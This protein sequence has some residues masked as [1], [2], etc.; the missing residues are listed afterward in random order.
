MNRTLPW[1]LGGAFAFALSLNAQTNPDGSADTGDAHDG[2]KLVSSEPPAQ[3]AKR[4]QW[5]SEARFGM[6]IHWGLYAQDGCFY[7]GQDGKTEHMMRHLQI[8]LKDYAK[9]ADD[10]NP[11]KFSADEWVG[12]A[13]NA[14]MKYMIITSKHH[15]G[16][17]MFNSPSSD[18]NIVK[19]TPWKRDPVKELAE[20]CRK[21]GLKFGAYYSL[22]RDWEDPDV[23]TRDGYR[24]NT[25][26]FPDESK[27]DFSK[28]FERKVKPQVRELLTQY[29]PIAV[30]WFDTPERISK[31]QS[32]EL[33]ALIHQLQ[34]DCIINARV[35]N[36]LGDYAVS[37]QKI[38]E[39]GDVKPWETCMTLNGHWGYK[40]DDEKW[41]P[42][43][44]LVRNLVDI[45]S[46]GGNFLL[47][48]GP[49]GEG[50]IPGPSVQH[51][52]E[53]GEWMRVNGEAIYGTTAG[54]FAKLDWGRCTK[55]VNGKETTLYLHVFDWPKDGKLFVPGLRGQIE[56]V[57]LL[58]T[59]KRLSTAVSENGLV[60]TVPETA[61]NKISATIAVKVSGPVILGA[62]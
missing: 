41:K 27:K 19:R 53:V 35:G 15:D 51:L 62:K 11:V 42:T 30:L 54:P 14:G 24:S 22:G 28:Y 55:K 4:L 44:T 1:L 57:S 5:W 39:S 12:I 49:T 13:K 45:A 23:P 21:Q 16:F 3:V 52:R 60:I 38:P 25:W 59:G 10:F 50:L 9:I 7:K 48:V 32:E 17:A 31:K 26:D 46:K 61:P 40:K 2:Q 56:S 36:R 8:P 43:E 18:Y 47:N 6:F 20:A 33:I 58:A 37:E 29:G 34:P